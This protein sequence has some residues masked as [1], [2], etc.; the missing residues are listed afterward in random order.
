MVTLQSAPKITEGPVLIVIAIVMPKGVTFRI[1][2]ATKWLSTQPKVR[3]FVVNAA[4]PDLSCRSGR[5]N[6]PGS[7]AYRANDVRWACDR[8]LE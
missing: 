7:N 3:T 2:Q 4:F 1:A 5:S 6:G 8:P